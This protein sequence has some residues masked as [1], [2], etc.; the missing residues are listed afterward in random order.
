MLSISQ[1]AV[2]EAPPFSRDGAIKRYAHTSKWALA[3]LLLAAFLVRVHYLR[4]HV[5]VLEGEGA[6][7]AHQADNLLRGLGFES[8]LYPKPDLEHCWLQP[9]LIAGTYLVVRDLDTATHI[10]SLV[11]G[12]LLVLWFFLLA[13]RHYGRSAAWIAALFAAFHPLIIALSTTGY[14][15]ILAAALQ[16]G[17]IYWSLR[18][19]EEDGRLSLALRG[20]VVGPLLSQSYRMP[21]DPDIH[22]RALLCLF[23]LEKR[24]SKILGDAQRTLRVGLC[25]I[26]NSLCHVISPLH[27]QVLV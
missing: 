20:R 8:Y 17:A 4:A 13:D 12:T 22:D 18:F 7:Y 3:L 11:S 19:I 9:I 24:L 2:S 16:F 23:S 27:W 14:A 6:G 1:P 21:A 5:V 10:V 26:C 25:S 15:E